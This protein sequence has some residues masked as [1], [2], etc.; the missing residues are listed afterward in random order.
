MAH[1]LALEYLV[2]LLQSRHERVSIVSLEINHA[3]TNHTLYF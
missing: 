3:A 1:A 2:A